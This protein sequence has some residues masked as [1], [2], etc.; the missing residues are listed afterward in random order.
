MRYQAA[1]H[2]AVTSKSYGQATPYFPVM[3]LLKRYAHVADTDDTRTMRA[4]VTGQ[5]LTLDDTLQDTL[6]ALL[7][8][9]DVL[10]DDSPFHQLDPTQRI[11]S[12]VRTVGGALATPHGR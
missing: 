9:L 12:H 8:L 2:P 1:L 11:A 7:A 5:V 4:K 3:D 6:P 10:P